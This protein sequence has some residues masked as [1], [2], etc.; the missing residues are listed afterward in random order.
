VTIEK[1]FAIKAE[2]A[3]IW[4]ALWSD[5]AKGDKDAFSVEHSTWPESL[6]LRVTLSGMP[7]ELTYRIEP[8]D[9]HCEVVATIQPLSSRYA[10][11]QVLTFGHLKR[12][13]EMLLVV[14]LSNLKAAVEGAPEDEAGDKFSTE[15]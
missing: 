1:A 12:N 15:D 10:L 13:Y 4:E 7:C 11:Y 3:A 9:G 14:G 2:P 5:L 6:S 8:R